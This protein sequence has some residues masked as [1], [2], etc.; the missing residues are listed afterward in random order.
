M[1]PLSTELPSKPQ[2][3][4]ARVV[5]NLLN[6]VVEAGPI[7]GEDECTVELQAAVQGM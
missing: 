4:R 5:L 6:A 2:S 3:Y 1:A 7:D